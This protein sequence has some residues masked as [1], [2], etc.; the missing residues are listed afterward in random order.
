MSHYRGCHPDLGLGFAIFA[1]AGLVIAIVGIYGV[2]AYSV[3]RRTHEIGVRLALGAD[4][5]RVSRMVIE[6]GL[7]ITL[8]GVSIGVVLAVAALRLMGSR[9]E[10]L[11]IG[12]GS[13]IGAVIAL[14][15]V[16]SF[17]AS[18]I[19]AIRAARLNP[20]DALRAE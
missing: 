12:Y 2:V 3:I 8:T 15:S 19:P 11:E 13:A 4:G 9:I 5:G 18:A 20:V 17:I 16:L 1:I 10:Q 14:V 7:K 6:Q